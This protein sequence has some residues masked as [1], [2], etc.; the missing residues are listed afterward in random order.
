MAI[1]TGLQFPQSTSMIRTVELE[2]G[3][4]GGFE[5]LIGID[6]RAAPRLGDFGVRS[7]VERVALC[8]GRFQRVGEKRPECREAQIDSVR[9]SSFRI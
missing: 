8:M 3:C 1:A 7:S 4:G 6:P 5:P 2:I 9:S